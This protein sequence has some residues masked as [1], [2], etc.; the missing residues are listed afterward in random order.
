MQV[1]AAD[2][3]PSKCLVSGD[4]RRAATQHRPASFTVAARDK[5]GNAVAGPLEGRMPITARG[6]S[7]IALHMPA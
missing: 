6:I 3:D 4:G 7:S 2:P 1:L 5:F